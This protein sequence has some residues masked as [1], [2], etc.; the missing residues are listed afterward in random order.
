MLTSASVYD[1]G[2]SYSSYLPRCLTESIP[3]D[4]PWESTKASNKSPYVSPPNTGVTRTYEFTIT[5][6][7]AAPDGVEA[8]L[9]LVNGQY[10]GPLIE[11][12]WGDWLQIVVHNN[13]SDEG[14]ALHWHGTVQK[15]S[16]WMD[17]VPGISQC[18]IAPGS[19]Y[20]Y[21]FRTDLYGTGWYHS[22]YEAQS[23]SGLAGPMVIYGPTH[24]EYDI[25]VGSIAVS[26]YFHEYFRTIAKGFLENKVEVTLS[27]NNLING[28]N[29]YNDNNAPRETFSF[30]SGKTH[31]LRLINMSAFAVEKVSIDGY[32]LTV[33]ANDYIPIKPYVTSVVTLAPG[34]RSDI[35]VYS[36]GAKPTDSMWLRAYKPPNC[37]PGKQGSYLALAA[38]FYEDADRTQAPTTQPGENSY[39]NYC[40]NDPLSQT[41]P[42]YPLTPDDPSVTEIVP[43]EL[44]PNGTSNL[45]YL[46][47]R[48]FRI[49]YNEPQLLGAKNGKL[50]FPWIQNV[51]DYGT[52]TS[53]RLIIENP[54]FQP[55]PMHLHGHN[56]WVLQ[57]GPCSDNE[58]IFPKGQPKSSRVFSPGQLSSIFGGLPDWFRMPRIYDPPLYHSIRMRLFNSTKRAQPSYTN[59]IRIGNYGTCWDGSIV[60]PTNPQLRDVHMLLPGSFVVIQWNQDNPGIWPLHCHIAWHLSAGFGWMILERPDDI[61]NVAE[62]PD[63]MARTCDEWTAWSSNHDANQIGAG[64]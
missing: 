8:E 36:T 17:G 53:I 5:K 10:P 1:I 48:T 38:I 44:R 41:M 31:R 52:N 32:N 24:V 55:H 62:I 45:W 9:L 34:Q 30:T 56:F 15:E 60:N 57:E 11:G 42:A 21:L 47:N 22:H 58:T 63:A 7:T 13:M 12:N 59:G 2:T 61:A 25:D 26:D 20:T 6:E 4:C 43:I 14:T 40:G 29:S 64:L 37:S 50:D 35:L 23:V 27:D 16:S 54:G 28:K 39:N 33:I 3:S 46:A 49:D 51:H 18:P 19:S